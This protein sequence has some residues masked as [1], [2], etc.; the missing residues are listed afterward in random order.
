VQYLMF[1]EGP[2]DSI[3]GLAREMKNLS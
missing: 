2:V 1:G 3:E